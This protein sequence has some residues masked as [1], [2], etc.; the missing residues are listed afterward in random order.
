MISLSNDIAVTLRQEEVCLY[1]VRDPDR[2]KYPSNMGTCA[3][4]I[5]DHVEISC[6]VDANGFAYVNKLHHHQQ[7]D[8]AWQGTHQGSISPLISFH[9]HSYKIY[10]VS[11][12][13]VHVLCTQISFLCT[14]RLLCVRSMSRPKGQGFSTN[15]WSHDLKQNSLPVCW[16]MSKPVHACM[17]LH[18]CYE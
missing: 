8:C 15:I 9:W 5:P 17:F 1:G 10:L 13:W 12:F 4:L 7:R 16:C 18:A 2:W 6:D 11:P 3:V 14:L